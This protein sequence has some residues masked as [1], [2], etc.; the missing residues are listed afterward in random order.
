MH[1]LNGFDVSR[2]VIS[3]IFD[4]SHLTLSNDALFSAAH[5]SFFSFLSVAVSSSWRRT[6]FRRVSVRLLIKCDCLKRF[7]V[8]RGR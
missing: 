8:S 4:K 6:L 1:G 5:A 3:V 7:G 2:G